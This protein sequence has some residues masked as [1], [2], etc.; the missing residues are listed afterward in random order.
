MQKLFFLFLSWLVI[1]AAQAQTGPPLTGTVTDA[2]SGERLPGASISLYTAGALT[3]MVSNAEG[4]FM[5][6]ATAHC[7][8]LKVSMIGYHSKTFYTN[9]FTGSR[10]LIVQL[11]RAPAV[12]QEVIVK[13]RNAIDIVKLAIAGIDKWLPAE[14][15]ENRCF[16]REIIK[17]RNSYFSVAEAVFRAQYHPQKHVYALQLV[18]GRSKEDVSY[19]RL[20]EDFHPG[21][22]PQAAVANDLILNRPDF[23]DLKKINQFTYAVDSVELF[24]GQLLYSISFDQKPGIKQALEKGRLLINTE[25]Y[26]IARY[27]AANSPAG[28]PYIKSLTGTD[29]LFARLL[30]IDFTKK[31][32]Q[33]RADFTLHN[34]KRQ[35]QYSTVSMAIAY[36]QPKKNIDLDLQLDIELVMTDL[37]LPFQKEIAKEEEW[38]K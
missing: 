18:E 25:D 5:L 20:F 4:K 3:G 10:G 38:E 1:G 9:D 24:D 6:A 26:S 29:K 36:K 14:N 19:T 30:N 23:L 13:A 17:D 7:D 32:W 34:G 33:R 35:L 12:L 16:Y 11:A 28:T 21:G 2:A 22:G 37:Q 8:S 31:G 15:F 27:E